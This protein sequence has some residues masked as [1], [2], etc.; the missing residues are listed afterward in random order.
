MPRLIQP[1]QPPEVETA[2]EII[3]SRIRSAIIRFLAQNGPSTSGE[4]GK[5]V[6]IGRP[7]LQVHLVALEEANAITAD[8]PHGARHGRNVRYEANLE[9]IEADLLPA[10]LRYIRGD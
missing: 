8:T 3:G 9:H 10:Y 5:G 2:I 4:I 7:S 6:N 1:R